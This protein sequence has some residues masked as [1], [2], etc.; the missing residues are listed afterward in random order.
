MAGADS[1]EQI[2]EAL[3]VEQLD[4][5]LFRSKTLYLPARARG[6]FGGQVISQ[7]LVSATNCVDP[8]YYLHVRLK[9]S[10]HCRAPF[11]H[12]RF[13]FTSPPVPSRES[14]LPVCHLCVHS[15]VTSVHSA[16]SSSAR[17]P[18]SPFFTMST[19]CAT[20]APMS[21]VPSVQSSGGAPSSR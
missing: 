8:A 13:Y 15:K 2:S 11:L 6:V 10:M 21:P 20:A 19:A 3:E 18:L 7:A 4:V 17:L 14:V 16:I 9:I 5:N 1:H 12:P